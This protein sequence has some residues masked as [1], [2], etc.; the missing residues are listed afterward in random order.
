M[1]GFFSHDR[2]INVRIF[3]VKNEQELRL[4]VKHTTMTGT[5]SC[6]DVTEEILNNTI[7]P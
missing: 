5:H 3:I 1:S 4:T 7:L 2:H 6:H